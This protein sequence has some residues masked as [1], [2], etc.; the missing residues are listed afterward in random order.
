MKFFIGFFILCFSLLFGNDYFVSISHAQCK[1][2]AKKYNANKFHYYNDCRLDI[3]EKACKSL[4]TTGLLHIKDSSQDG[5]C[6]ITKYMMSKQEQEK[7]NEELKK[8]Y[9]INKLYVVSDSINPTVIR[10]EPNIDSEKIGEYSD[11]SGLIALKQ[12]SNN[13]GLTD[14]GWVKLV[15]LK[16]AEGDDLE[17]AK[18]LGSWPGR[19]ATFI[20]SISWLIFFSITLLGRTPDLRYST[21]FR[22][23]SSASFLLGLGTSI[24]IYLFL[25]GIYFSISSLFS[26]EWVFTSEEH[27]FFQHAFVNF[28]TSP[29][30]L[31]IHFLCLLQ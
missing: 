31:L 9:P 2:L 19:V 21:G 28:L 18:A 25:F 26:L 22:P 11:C 30:A 4:S 17:N 12:I 1:E 5:E 23:V 20:A 13:W 3:S 27:S 6:I 8:N 14:K 15:N 29:F 24:F 7:Y 16:E 10:K